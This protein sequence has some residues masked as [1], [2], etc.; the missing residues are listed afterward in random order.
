[1]TLEADEFIRRF[2]I[3]V[4]PPGFPRIRHY[5][6]LANRHRKEDLALCRTL[7]SH[8]VTELLPGT[9]QCLLLLAALTLQP[10]IPCPK[11]RKGIMIRLGFLPAC[12]WPARPPDTS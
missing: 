8:P 12:L 1:M 9:V 4:L 6:L 5:G 2:L 7:L 10:P 3:H 11:C